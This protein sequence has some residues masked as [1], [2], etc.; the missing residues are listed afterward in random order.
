MLDSR[1]SIVKQDIAAN[2]LYSSSETVGD[3]GVWI[4]PSV[5]DQ[6]ICVAGSTIIDGIYA[7][8]QRPEFAPV[9]E[10]DLAWELEAWEAAS[11]EALLLFEA[12]C[13]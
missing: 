3:V 13:E 5:S 2:P 7:Q 8:T 9:I 10:P 12:E 11:D 4:Q 1:T 6:A